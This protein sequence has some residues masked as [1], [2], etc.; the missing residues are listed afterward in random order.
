MAS[1]PGTIS[2]AVGRAAGERSKPFH[3]GD[4]VAV[5]TSRAAGQRSKPSHLGRST[6]GG[7]VAPAR[8]FL[9]RALRTSAPTG[10]VTWPASAPD[11][12]GAAYPDGAGALSLTTISLAGT[13]AP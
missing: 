1:N 10:W 13:I 2:S 3:A 11:L 12:S 8:R 6:G 7:S 9:M 4:L 5:I